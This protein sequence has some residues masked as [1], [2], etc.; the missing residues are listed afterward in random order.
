MSWIPSDDGEYV[1][2][3]RDIA[4]VVRRSE[5]WCRYVAAR[6]EDALPV[7]KIGGIWRLRREDLA[8]WLGRQRQTRAG[9]PRMRA[10]EVV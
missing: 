3:W 4:A 5:R 6:A 9:V 8:N 2:T 1:E 7:Y 10:G